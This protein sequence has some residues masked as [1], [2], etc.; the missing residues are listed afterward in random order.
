MGLAL[1]SVALGLADGDTSLD[2]VTANESSDSVRTRTGSGDGTFFQG[3]APRSA[4]GRD[5][6]VAVAFANVLSGTPKDL[7]VVNF[8]DNSLSI[9]AASGNGSYFLPN[10]SNSNLSVGTNPTAVVVADVDGDSTV[11]LIVTNSVGNTM[12]VIRQNLNGTFTAP[13]TYAVGAGASG[14][15]VG[16][17]NGDSA[18]DLVVTN[19]TDGTV[20][21]LLNNGNG[22]FGSQ[23]TLPAGVNP[24]SV[25]LADLNRAAR[26]TSSRR[27]S[28]TIRWAS[29]WARATARSVHCRRSPPA[30]ARSRSPSRTSM[31]TPS[32]T[33]WS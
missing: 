9:F 22:T 13:V 14:V 26:S 16:N 7:A 18:L 3:I 8:G 17:L 5:R 31:A 32:R 30:P 15:A 6:P 19:K 25:A 33:W 23:A 21:I 20:S 24:T 1:S 2:I 28:P 12:T 27:A 4:T 10:D 29:D 11:D